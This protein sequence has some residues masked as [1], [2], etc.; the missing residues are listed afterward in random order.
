MQFGQLQAP[1]RAGAGLGLGPSII[2]NNI[3]RQSDPTGQQ[4]DRTEIM[5]TPGPHQLRITPRAIR[6][7]AR[8]RNCDRTRRASPLSMLAASHKR[9]VADGGYA[10]W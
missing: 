8:V 10:L 7:F 6:A 3:R 1:L 5:S 4:E 9:E 2:R